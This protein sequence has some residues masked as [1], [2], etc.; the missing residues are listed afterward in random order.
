[1][2]KENSTNSLNRQLLLRYCGMT[3]AIGL[4]GGRWKPSILMSLL[5]GKLRYS[6]IRKVIPGVSERVLVLQLRELERDGLIHRI[7]YPA[8]PPKS[9]Y[10][11][12]EEGMSM[13]PMLEAIAEWG[14]SHRPDHE[15]AD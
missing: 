2:R 7:V 15:G 14:I 11:L 5:E 12:T 6:E 3:Y 4:I 13:R 10:E 9:E 1:M 8:V